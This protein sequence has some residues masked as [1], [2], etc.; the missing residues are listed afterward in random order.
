LGDSGCV[1]A[2]F[3]YLPARQTMDIT[4]ATHS[5]VDEA[6]RVLVA[7]F[8]EDPITGFL[9]ATGPGYPD[10]VA[11]FFSI[12]M[13]V[14]ICLDMPVILARGPDGI[15]GAAMGYT[16]VRPRWPENLSEE[17]SHF[18]ESI[19]GMADRM[20]QY[21]DIAAK[22][23]P[24]EPHYYLG[25][26]GVDPKV[27]GLGVG[28]RL[29]TGFCE[30]SANDPL[31]NGVYLETAQPSNVRFYQRAGFAEAGRGSLGS[32][33][34]WCMFRP[35]AGGVGAHAGAELGRQARTGKQWS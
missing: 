20:A 19:H 6:V 12:L 28:S 13:R 29:L 3:G 18:E 8:A 31:S 14:R 33:S 23:T 17:W 35:R 34:L 22:F 11:G 25:V 9:L 10:R 16:T 24:G 15:Q 32:R 5:D 21:E 26:I 4:A 27:R 7:A 2:F 1:G 30:L